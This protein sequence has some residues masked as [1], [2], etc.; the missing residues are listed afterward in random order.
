MWRIVRGLKET[1]LFLRFDFV[2][3]ADLS[4]VSAVVAKNFGLVESLQRRVAAS[5]PVQHRTVWLDSELRELRQG[6]PLL[7]RLER[8]YRPAREGGLDVNLRPDRWPFVDLVA[9]VG[10]WEGLCLRARRRAEERI[11]RDA[12][13]TAQCRTQADRVLAGTAEAADVFRNR[14]PRLTGTQRVA[15][16]GD[17]AIRGGHRKRYCRRDRHP[18]FRVDAAGAVF[19]SGSPLPEGTP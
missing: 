16:R 7:E 19:L 15:R 4:G 1:R 3:E 13:F 5:F 11:R 2:I 10:D 9:P 18:V 17:G 8:P 6:T 12:Q 14:L